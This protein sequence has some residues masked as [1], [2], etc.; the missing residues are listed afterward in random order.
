MFEHRFNCLQAIL[1][2]IQA[3]NLHVHIEKTFLAV[4]NVDYLGYQITT[5]GSMPQAEKIALI[6]AFKPPSN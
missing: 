6:L 1:K 4:Q 2:E 5:K 3:N